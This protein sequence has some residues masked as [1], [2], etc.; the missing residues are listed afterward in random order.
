MSKAIK[1]RYRRNFSLLIAFHLMLIAYPLISK[2][3]H[4]HHR[5][6]GHHVRSN[7]IAFEHPDDFC[8]IYNFEFYSFVSTPLIKA[9]VFWASIPVYN[10]PA[11]EGRYAQMI[12]HFSL[13]AP[14]IA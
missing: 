3:V 10:S 13:R 12:I 4:V 5:E 14:P 7:Q 9:I 6:N 11:P 1:I 8:P 2:T